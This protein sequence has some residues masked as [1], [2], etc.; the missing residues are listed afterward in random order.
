MWRHCCSPLAHLQFLWCC[1]FRQSGKSSCCSAQRPTQPVCQ[2]CQVGG[3]HAAAG[4]CRLL[5]SKECPCIAWPICWGPEQPL[6]P[7]PG[8]RDQGNKQVTILRRNNCL[9]RNDGMYAALLKH[10]VHVSSCIRCTWD[11]CR[12]VPCFVLQ[13]TSCKSSLQWCHGDQPLVM[14]GLDCSTWHQL[15]LPD[16]DVSYYSSTP[17]SNVPLMPHYIANS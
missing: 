17:H 16:S 13:L 1:R 3:C 8:E 11:A 15:R 4:G 7:G 12:C 10:S 9:L 2:Q 6:E 5:G 14:S